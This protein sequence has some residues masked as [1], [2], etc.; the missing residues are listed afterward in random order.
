[1][2]LMSCVIAFAAQSQVYKWVDEKGVTHYSET[3]PAANR[4]STS[5][6]LQRGPS[7]ERVR[8]AQ[9]RLRQTQEGIKS[10]EDE[11]RKAAMKSVASAGRSGASAERCGRA[12]QQLAVLESENVGVVAAGGG[13][14]ATQ[15]ERKA[16]SDFHLKEVAE[17]CKDMGPND[18]RVADAVRKNAERIDKNSTC[19]NARQLLQSLSDPQARS[20]SSEV[21]NARAQVRALC[22]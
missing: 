22:G 9:E 4:K 15:A 10:R 19:N 3:P 2:F 20:S 5:V 14:V 17:H 8:D 18:G 11:A 13:R 6:E 1:M 12:R 21:D 16:A 7:D